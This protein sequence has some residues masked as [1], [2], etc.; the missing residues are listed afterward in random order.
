MVPD[1]QFDEPGVV[2]LA[3]RTGAD[4]LAVAQ[5]RDPIGELEHLV[6][7]V[8]Y[9]QDRHAARLQAVDHLEQASHV[10][11][12]KGGGRLV[13]DQQIGPLL[14]P[15]EGAGDGDRPCGATVAGSRRGP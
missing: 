6:E 4:P 14:P 11:A 5:H 2:E 7:V 9:V 12:W 13:E 1:D 8:R 15:D 3:D 10:V